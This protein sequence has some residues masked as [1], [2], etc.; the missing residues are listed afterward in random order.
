M[1]EKY[2]K[3]QLMLLVFL[4]LFLSLGVT[5]TI[6]GVN[7]KKTISLKYQ[8]TNDID[9][10]VYLKENDFF[11][12]EYIPAGKTYITSLIDH[13]EVNYKYNIDF[14]E[15]V[16]ATY[17]YKVIAE[18]E[19]NKSDTTAG[20]NYWTKKYDIT[21]ESTNK[22]SKLPNYTINQQISVD[23]NKFNAM[24]NEFKKSVGLSSSTGILKVS[25]AI[26]SDVST[27]ELNTPIKS[28]LTLQLPLS[29][30]AIEA[31]IESDTNNNVKEIKKRVKEK[32]ATYTFLTV[33]GI[34]SI[35]LS[36]FIIIVLLRSRRLYKQSYKYELEL[37]KIL[38]TYDSIIVN[39][40]DL[41]DI[42]NYNIIKVE[43][44]EELI[45]AHSEIRKPINYYNNKNYSI[46]LLISDNIAWK[47]I[48]YKHKRRRIKE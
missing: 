27:E 28:D 6:I 37:D 31:S 36:I 23:Y 14:S 42:E 21:E 1:K 45:D 43:S 7:T 12:E 24:L 25:L 5:C 34:F 30:L 44:F 41:P 40:K 46:F 29:E 13:I 10:K 4:L 47:Y 35:I 26:T 32:G 38:S 18:I 2:A 20:G 3:R 16:D 48:L 11:E 19:A 33:I 9:Y 15:N 22:I 17:K 39:I 8:E